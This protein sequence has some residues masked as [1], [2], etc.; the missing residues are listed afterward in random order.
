MVRMV[1]PENTRERVDGS[2]RAA[3]SSRRAHFGRRRVGVPAR[4]TAEPI[5]RSSFVERTDW[6]DLSHRYSPGA[7][8]PVFTRR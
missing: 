5:E 8:V 3:R 6:C 7:S 2:R 1:G 4:L